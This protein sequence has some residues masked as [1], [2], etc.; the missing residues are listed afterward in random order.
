VPTTLFRTPTKYGVR[1]IEMPNTTRD[2]LREMCIIA[3]MVMRRVT[4]MEFGNLN[5]WL[6]DSN[7][8]AVGCDDGR[9]IQSSSDKLVYPIR[10]CLVGS[11]A[12]AFNEMM[13]CAVTPHWNKKTIQFILGE[14][15]AKCI[16]ELGITK[17][18]LKRA[19]ANMNSPWVIIQ[20][21]P[22]EEALVSFCK[23]TRQAGLEACAFAD[24]IRHGGEESIYFPISGAD[25]QRLAVYE[26][27]RFIHDTL[28]EL[29]N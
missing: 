10:G 9:V 21:T 1:G 26:F 29:E 23:L 4:T 22:I 13:S 6:Q 28:K 27:K 7:G 18:N 16:P 19:A 15:I 11:T 5:T 24:K 20:L 12:V 14:F 17:H 2:W 25:A 3:P 8:N